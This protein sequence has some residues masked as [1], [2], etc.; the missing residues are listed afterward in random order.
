[1]TGNTGR[2]E[3]TLLAATICAFMAG[4]AGS[5]EVAAFSGA[6][7]LAFVG[8]WIYAVTQHGQN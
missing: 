6:L 4:A 1:M 3:I 2:S 7:T 5:V 8:L